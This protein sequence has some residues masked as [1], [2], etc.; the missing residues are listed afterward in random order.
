MYK[1]DVVKLTH[2]VTDGASNFSKAFNE[3]S[4]HNV[5][6][7]G[8]EESNDDEMS[9]TEP[10]EFH[11]L[12]Q[13]L[14][15][16]NLNDTQQE[17]DERSD[18]DLPIELP[19]Q[20]K[21]TSHTLNLIASSD[22][23]TALTTPAYGRV[24]HPVMAKCQGIWNAVHRSTKASDCVAE[25]CGSEKKFVIP[26]ATRWNSKYDAICRILELSNKLADICEALRLP[27]FKALEMEFLREFIKVLA[28][29]STTLDILQGETDCFFGMILPKLVL[30]RNRLHQL[31]ESNL[32]YVGPLASALL[33]GIA[34]RYS[35][36]M[37]LDLSHTNVKS[38]IVASVSNPKYKLLWVPPD[39]RETVVA[40][41]K[42][43]VLQCARTLNTHTDSGVAIA[44]NTNETTNEDCE[45]DYGFNEAV[46]DRSLAH[47]LEVQI[48]SYMMDPDKNLKMLDKYPEVKAVFMKFNTT[49]PSSGAVERLF[50]VAGQI[51]TPRRNRLSDKMFQ[52]LLLL[53][54]NKHLMQELE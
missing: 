28:P 40:L 9:D 47:K 53:R 18:D 20:L 37:E 54:A 36:M 44:A 35:A 16:A 23:N 2:T 50:S 26:C 31:K 24:Y 52:E 41:F 21:C 49:L 48:A 43:C 17:Q 5:D 22:A 51:Q 27:K 7:E 15:D 32:K 39:K 30:L 12:Q 11:D 6:N 14:N 29:L 34:K 4:R 1:L 46:R 8:N 38:A 13:I 25:I 19:E 42:E 10:I 3:Y 45:D 33:D